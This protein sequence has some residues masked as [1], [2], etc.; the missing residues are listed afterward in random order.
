MINVVRE[1]V[2]SILNKNNYG[3]ISP[4]DFNLFAKQAQLDLFEDYF[5]TFNKQIV[6]ENSRFS[7]TDA[8]DIN[9]QIQEVIDSFT[10][11]KDLTASLAAGSAQTFDLPTDWYTL[12]EV[13]WG[14]KLEAAITHSN[15]EAERVSEYSIRRLI[16]S[17][18]TSPSA[19][20]PAYVISQQGQPHTE[21][22]GTANYGNLSNQIT[23]YPAPTAGSTLTCDLVYTRY[24]LD[25]NWTY[26]ELTSGEAFFNPN[27]AGYQDFELP[28]SDQTDLVLK[29]LQYAGMSIREIQAV[30][31]GQV[32]EQLETQSQDPIPQTKKIR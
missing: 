2:L 9:R 20:F 19:Q 18:I 7:G 10:Q 26:S 31:F 25:P 6:A 28:Q 22:S 30:T 13:L 14:E 8:A 4:I 23:L 24:P 16:R 29:I 5:Y 32:Q 11:Y 17:N 1:T 3:Y 27:I 12:I 21:G 15:K